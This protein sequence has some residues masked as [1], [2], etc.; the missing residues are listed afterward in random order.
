MRKINVVI[1]LISMLMVSSC[2]FDFDTDMHG[3]GINSCELSFVTDNEENINCREL[4]CRYFTESEIAILDKRV[5]S[6]RIDRWSERVFGKTY[7]WYNPVADAVGNYPYTSEIVLNKEIFDDVYK[8]EASD[9]ELYMIQVTLIHELCHVLWSDPNSKP[10]DE[11]VPSQVSRKNHND[12]WYYGF[13]DKVIAFTTNNNMQKFRIKD[14]LAKYGYEKF[15]PEY[16][17][18]PGCRAINAVSDECCNCESCGGVIIY[19][20]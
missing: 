7:W 8:Y 9:A 12:E 6:I 13:K 15:G 20:N 17:Y 1:V 4:I 14:A 2:A 19:M 16:N 10:A 18:I 3:E 11:S 5:R